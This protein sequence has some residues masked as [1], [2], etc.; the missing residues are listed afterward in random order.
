MQRR[1]GGPA[2]QTARLRIGIRRHEPGSKADIRAQTED[3]ERRDHAQDDY[4]C[5]SP[6]VRCRSYPVLQSKRA[7]GRLQKN[8]MR[9]EE[10]PGS[11]RRANHAQVSRYFCGLYHRRLLRKRDSERH[12]GW[13]PAI[14]GAARD[15]RRTAGRSAAV[16][17][18]R[19]QRRPQPA[20][21]G[22]TPTSRNCR[23]I[24]TRTTISPRCRAISIRISVKIRRTA[25]PSS[26]F[27]QRR[28]K[29]R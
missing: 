16:R 10:R 15:G 11:T 6:A 29:F 28:R 12:D 17:S 4:T 3:D 7:S 9:G 2:L 14:R 27:P 1:F 25:F 5:H 18:F 20:R 23:S 22:G 13:T 8:S 21:T 26:S 24:R 19:R